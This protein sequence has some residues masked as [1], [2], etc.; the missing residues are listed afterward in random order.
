MAY[1]LAIDPG[2]DKNGICI[3]DYE[4]NVLKHY[5]VDEDNLLPKIKME[6][7]TYS[8][9]EII[10]GNGTTKKYKLKSLKKHFPQVNILIVD[11]YKTT[12]E[13]RIL[14]WKYNKPKFW[15]RFLPQTMRVP[16]CAID[17][18]AAMSIG[19]RYLQKKED[20]N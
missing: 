20:G 8:I 18:Y 6:I 19:Y 13:G 2:K 11:E 4:G 9:A 16:S 10:L 1:F 12:E 3:M 7:E 5:I 14:Y 15:Q 17:D